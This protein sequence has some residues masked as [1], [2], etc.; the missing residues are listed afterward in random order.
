MSS[1]YHTPIWIIGL[2]TV[3]V[4]AIAQEAGFRV[5]R[6]LGD[7]KRDAAQSAVSS[8][9]ALLGLLTAFTFGAAQERF[10]A[11]QRLVVQE[12][13]AIGTAFLRAQLLQDPWRT[14]LG[15][16]LQRYA[17]VRA[18]IPDGEAGQAADVARET[19]AIEAPIWRT[20]QGAVQTN[21][22]PTLNAPLLQAI[23]EMFDLGASRQAAQ[24][25]RVPVTILRSLWIFAIAT[26]VLAGLAAPKD[27][28]FGLLSQSVLLLTTLALCLILDLDRPIIVNQSAM[29]GA[30]AAIRQNEAATLRRSPAASA[31]GAGSQPAS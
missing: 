13:N 21:P 3:A 15:R 24:A 14:D 9:L 28:R 11:R 12:A 5:G 7:G 19:S 25:A 10:D 27:R 22:I 8:A 30:V 23:N 4:L 16:Q 2:A 6:L 1:L 18:R 31:V 29:A 26:A 20:V 17:E